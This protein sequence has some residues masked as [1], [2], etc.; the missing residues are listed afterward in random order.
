MEET[1]KFSDLC[2]F[3]EKQKAAHDAVKD[4]RYLLYGGAMGGGKSYWLRW[5]TAYW[6]SY[7]T[8]KYGL[9]KIVGGLFCEDYPSLKDRQVSKIAKEFPDWLGDLH[10]DH[11]EYGRSFIAKPEYGSWVLA[12]RNLDDPSKYKSAEFAVISIDEL[13]K[14]TKEVFDDL[15]KTR[16]RWPGIKSEDCKFFSGTNPGEVGHA[17]VKKWWLDRDFEDEMKAKAG[18]FT[19]ISAKAEDNLHLDQGYLLDLASLPEDKRKAYKDGDWNIFKGQYFSEWRNEIHVVDPFPLPDYWRRF[20]CGDYGYAAPSAVY[21]CAIDEDG[22]IY[23]YRELYVT[24]HTYERLMEV[25]VSMTP[26][27]E[28]IEYAV[29]DPAIWAKKGD[30]E[31]SGA[32]KMQWK[33]KELKKQ[34]INLQRGNNERVIGWGQVREYLKPFV[35]NG[36]QLAKLQVFKTCTNLIRTLPALVYDKNRVEDVDSDGEDHAPDSIRYGIMSRPRVSREVDDF[37]LRKNKSKKKL[38]YST[39]MA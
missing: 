32:E 25:I 11:K 26:N 2:G 1:I 28:K 30:S 18:E 10:A 29:F 36:Q 16:L 7:L 4:F 38:P 31:L 34:A 12:L 14:N 39:R 15:P 19:Y 24:E 27:N 8:K 21:W 6:L 9:T 35:R 37:Y 23:V 3:S 5:E 13:T 17:W 20:I 33:Y 22:V